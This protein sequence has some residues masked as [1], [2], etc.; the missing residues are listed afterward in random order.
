MGNVCCSESCGIAL[1]TSYV[2]TGG[3]GEAGRR[4]S[5][6][7]S[8]GW[9]HDLGPLNQGRSAHACAKFDDESGDTGSQRVLL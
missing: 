6:Y 7:T 1:A 8:S 4:A 2:V 5:L 9:S 3:R